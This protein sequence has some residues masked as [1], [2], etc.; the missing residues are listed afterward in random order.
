VPVLLRQSTDVANLDDGWS[1]FAITGTDVNL[2]PSRKLPD[3][4]RRLEEIFESVRD[5]WWAMGHKLGQTPSA[6]LAHMPTAASYNCD[7]GLMMAWT[8]LTKAVAAEP[9]LCLVVCDDPWMFRELAAVDGVKA[10]KPPSLYA[11]AFKYWARGWLARGRFVF[12]VIAAHFR[13]RKTRT[14]AI[15]G[16]SSLL[17]YGHPGSDSEGHDAYFGSLMLEMP[18]L[19]RLVH[20]DGAV[21]LTLKL[22]KDGRTAG[23]H[24]W[25]S[26]LFAPLLFFQRW[27]PEPGDL[28]GPYEWILRRVVIFENATAAPATNRWQMHCQDRWLASCRP[29]TVVWPWENHP[30]ERA[31]CRSARRYGVVAKGYQHAV[32]GPHQF[33]PGPASNPDGLD[34]IP[35]RIICSGPAYHDQLLSWGV[36]Q[37][38]LCIGGAFR[39]ARFEGN[40]YDPDGP[41]F[42]AT[43]SFDDIT[44]Q[45]MEAVTLAQKPG[46]EFIVKV[47]PLYPQDITETDTVK[48]TTH[49]IPEQKGVSA[50]FYGTG[51]SGLEGLLAGVPTL[52]FQ[53]DDRVAINVLPEAVEAQPVSLNALGN[54]LDHIQKPPPLDWESIYATVDLSLWKQELNA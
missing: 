54:A 19:R 27:R 33:N 20:T 13:L 52:R 21:D 51:T 11:K 45:M 18:K 6:R 36:P 42:V 31:M 35:G 8:K 22:A 17:V 16:G 46:R 24:A 3:I 39:I 49:T 26:P 34:S 32:I 29:E 7:F 15:K 50:V 23:L 47:H 44:K 9:G 4:G 38:R 41:V 28:E 40:H 1:W 14:N 2:D 25:G 37:E 53:S 43:S 30:W 10:G 48:L 5:D 12:S